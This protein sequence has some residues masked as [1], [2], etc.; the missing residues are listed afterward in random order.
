MEPLPSKSTYIRTL[1][2]SVFFL[3]VSLVINF[4]AAIYSTDRASNPVTDI[5]LSNT[6]VHNVGG[7]F[8]YGAVLFI[9]VIVIA[10]ISSLRGL[11]FVLKA[12]ALF[13]IIR[14]GFISLTHISIYPNHVLITSPFF[15]NRYLEGVFTGNDLFFSGHTGLPFLMALIF[16]NLPVYRFVFLGFSIM[17]AV[18][19][20]LGHIHYSIDVAS[21]FFI[22]YSIFEI[23]KRIFKHDWKLFL[24]IHLTPPKRHIS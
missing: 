11:P 22:T 6:N 20:L 16:W 14:S 21:A 24:G 18:I 15:A 1:I 7:L 10:C 19:V 5:V 2:V 23:A 13:T 17:F 8:T 9:G 12:I 3:V 4:F